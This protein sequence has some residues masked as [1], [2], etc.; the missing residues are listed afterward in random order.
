MSRHH[1]GDRRSTCHQQPF[2]AGSDLPSPWRSK[3]ALHR[4]L[5]ASAAQQQFPQQRLSTTP[6]A[7]LCDKENL[8]DH[9]HNRPKQ[10]LNTG[11]PT[12]HQPEPRR[13]WRLI[14]EAYFGQ[15]ISC[16][17]KKLNC[18]IRILLN[19]NSQRQSTRCRVS[20]ICLPVFLLHSKNDMKLQNYWVL[21]TRAPLEER[22]ERPKRTTL[23]NPSM[24]Q[25]QSFL[26]KIACGLHSS[27][28][29][30]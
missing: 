8:T 24:C 15:G 29:H 19:K 14:L 10:T 23:P 12:S 17:L 20:C 5:P 4:H 21:T 6:T 11:K 27:F 26:P 16:Y 2:W 13:T 1:P 18:S 3:E 9:V 30:L 25:A 7:V 22:N 28:Y